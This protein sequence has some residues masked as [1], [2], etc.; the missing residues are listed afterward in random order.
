MNTHLLRIGAAAAILSVI[1]QLAAAMLEPAR[2][3]D[4]D[5]AIRTIAES[6]AWT[7]RWLV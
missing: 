4:A 1:V 2:V 3:G 6:G 5:K 7:G